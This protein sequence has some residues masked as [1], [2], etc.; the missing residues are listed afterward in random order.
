MCVHARLFTLKLP[1]LEWTESQEPWQL[2]PKYKTPSMVIDCYFQTEVSV[3]HIQ[4][5]QVQVLW[6]DKRAIRPLEDR[7]GCSFC[8]IGMLSNWQYTA[9]VERLEILDLA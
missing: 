7:Y 2:E 1:K 5:Y 3:H 8:N 6:Y 9:E 4:K